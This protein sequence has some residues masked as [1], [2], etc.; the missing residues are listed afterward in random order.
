MVCPHG[1]TYPVAVQYDG[2]PTVQVDRPQDDPADQTASAVDR[3][4]SSEDPAE[5]MRVE[6][7]KAE[8]QY[9]LYRPSPGETVIVVHRQT[10]KSLAVAPVTWDDI[11][12][13]YNMLPEEILSDIAY[14]YN[15]IHG[16]WEQVTW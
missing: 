9:G 13:H 3:V 7:E 15:D 10:S 8:E 2:S 11:P 12:V 14:W 1:L 5:L 4:S 6:W 16:D